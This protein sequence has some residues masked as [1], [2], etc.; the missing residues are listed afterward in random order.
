ML[1]SVVTL[2]KGGE[3]SDGVYTVHTKH[4]LPIILVEQLYSSTAAPST[5][6]PWTF[7]L[8]PLRSL[9]AGMQITRCRRKRG[10]IEECS[11]I[12]RRYGSK[13]YRASPEHKQRYS[14]PPRDETNEE[15]GLEIV[16]R[17]RLSV[18]EKGYPTRLNRV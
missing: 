5:R 10:G 8:I 17:T 12:L 14:H 11:S 16:L 7:N 15:N 4:H 13:C 3:V 9:S 1:I 6:S 18:R 2:Y